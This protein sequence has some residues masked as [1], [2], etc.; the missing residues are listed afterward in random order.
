MT[1]DLRQELYEATVGLQQRPASVPLLLRTSWR[2]PIVPLLIGG[3]RQSR[4]KREQLVVLNW[5]IRDP[6]TYAALS[7]WLGGETVGQPTSVRYE[8]AL[9]RAT[10]I[11]HGLGLIARESGW[12]TLTSKALELV[13]QIEESES[14]MHERGLLDALPKP[15]PFN[16]AEALLGGALR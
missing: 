3:C 15:I 14:Y 11:A 2:V 8:P 9:V 4:A 7:A 13:D 16:A 10:N 1:P 6:R 5:A 12:M